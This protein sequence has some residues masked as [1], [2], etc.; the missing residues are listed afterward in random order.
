MLYL[1]PRALVRSNCTFASLNSW[2]TASWISSSTSL[3]SPTSVAWIRDEASEL[4]SSSSSW[5]V[6]DH[7]IAGVRLGCLA[8]RTAL[9]VR[10]QQ[11]LAEFRCEVG[12]HVALQLVGRRNGMTSP[13]QQR[14]CV[15]FAQQKTIG[16]GAELSQFNT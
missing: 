8:I 4:S 13:A 15:S 9:I 16:F 12:A 11:L 3:G 1:V 10:L 14:G 6:Y 2:T 5:M 7:R